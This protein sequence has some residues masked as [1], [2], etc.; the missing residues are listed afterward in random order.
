MGLNDRCLE[1]LSDWINEMI[2]KIDS[3]NFKFIC[4]YYICVEK[5]GKGVKELEDSIIKEIM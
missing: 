1:Y 2:Q 3:E 4:L 5:T